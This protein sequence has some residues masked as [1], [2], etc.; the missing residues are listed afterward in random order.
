M[1][2]FFGLQ[3]RLLK[4]LRE[5]KRLKIQNGALNIRAYNDFE[6]TNGSPNGEVRISGPVTRK[7]LSGPNGEIVFKDLPP[8]KC[9]V[10]ATCGQLTLVQDLTEVEIAPLTCT[11][12]G[13][14]LNCP[15][16]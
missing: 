10:K 8:S 14:H 5:A 12:F 16:K 13:A 2:S 3:E 6:R 7:S 15:R 1:R 9:K 11:W 4:Y